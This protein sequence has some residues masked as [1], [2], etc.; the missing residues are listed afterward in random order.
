M[1]GLA[2]VQCEDRP[3]FVH[4]HRAITN[5]ERTGISP[6]RLITGN[7]LLEAGMPPSS[8]LGDILEAVYDAQLEG[9]LKTREDAISL[10]LAM[11]SDF[12]DS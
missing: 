2:I 3:L 5:L 9:S 10:A 11:Y 12:Q 8:T 6:D 4:I 1:S 7:D